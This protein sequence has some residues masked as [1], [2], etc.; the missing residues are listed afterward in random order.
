[1]AIIHIA[2]AD[3][4]LLPRDA[5]RGHHAEAL[6]KVIVAINGGRD[7]LIAGGPIEEELVV[8]AALCLVQR[9]EDVV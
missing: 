4:E 2:L 5:L 7:P 6:A 3:V 8:D 1:M 9:S